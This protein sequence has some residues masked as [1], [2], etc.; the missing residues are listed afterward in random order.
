MTRALLI[1]SNTTTALAIKLLLRAQ[2]LI[3]ESTDLGEDAVQIGKLYDFD[4]I[5]LDP[6]LPDIDGYEVLRQLRASGVHTP[7]LLL[8]ARTDLD[9][10]LKGL[11]FGADDF[12]TKPFEPRELIARIQAIVR[13]SNGHSQ[14][15]IRTGKLTVNIGSR[16]VAV[17]DRAIH[18]TPKEYGMIELLSLRKGTVLTKET[19][20][21]H[22]YGDME[23]PEPKIID[24]FICK[25]RKKL[26]LATSGDHYIETVW[27][28][29]YTMRE[30]VDA[31]VPVASSLNLRADAPDIQPGSGLLASTGP[32]P[33]LLGSLPSTKRR[34]GASAIP[35]SRAHPLRAVGRKTGVCVPKAPRSGCARQ[36]RAA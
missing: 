18:V 11:A 22:L 16:I 25:L 33:Q 6:M 2:T 12:M 31:I 14:S 13:R 28:R 26:A 32:S 36:A 5:I 30:P 15:A 24:V 27:G 35:Q 34:S 19:F 17:G 7:V 21:S 9:Y 23:E 4:I 1:E 10:Q 20:L 29:G 8:S 3:V